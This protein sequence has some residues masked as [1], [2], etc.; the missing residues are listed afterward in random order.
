MNGSAIDG[1]LYAVMRCS[2]GHEISLIVIA[3]AG[4]RALDIPWTGAVSLDEVTVVGIHHSHEAD[5]MEC[6][7]R[8]KCSP[9][10]F[11]PG[12][13]FGDEIRQITGRCIDPCW[14]NLSGG[15]DVHCHSFGRSF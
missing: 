14:L 10:A 2:F 5:E 6:G 4:Q 15:F 8:M 9:E 11:G 1:F 7:L 13:Y 3:F 12:C